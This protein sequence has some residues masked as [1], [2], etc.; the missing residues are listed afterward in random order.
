[1]STVALT[2]LFFI[3]KK[4]KRFILDQGMAGHAFNLSIQE[5]EQVDL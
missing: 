5:A 2:D 3:L 1:M 4:K